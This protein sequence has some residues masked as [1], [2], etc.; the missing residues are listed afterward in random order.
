MTEAVDWDIKPQTKHNK[1]VNVTIF[2][3]ILF[4]FYDLVRMKMEGV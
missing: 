4:F 3:I 2:R 1:K